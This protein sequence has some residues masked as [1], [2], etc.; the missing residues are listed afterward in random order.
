M[1][2]VHH[3]GNLDLDEAIVLRDHRGQDGRADGRLV[4]AGCPLRGGRRGRRS[5]PSIATAATWASPSRSPTTCW[6]SGARS[7][8]TGKSLGTDLEKQKLTLPVIRLLEIG[9]S[10]DR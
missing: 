3:R 6:T 10:R 7:A 8:S 5:R 9:R 2:Q 1:Q 4:P